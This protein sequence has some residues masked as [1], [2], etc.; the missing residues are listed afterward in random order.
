MGLGNKVRG[1]LDDKCKSKNFERRGKR[2]LKEVENLAT[3]C[4]ALTVEGPCGR[5]ARAEAGAEHTQG[6]LLSEDMRLSEEGECKWQP[7]QRT[8]VKGDDEGEREVDED[9]ERTM[10]QCWN[11]TG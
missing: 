4:E 9:D 6:T 10:F 8:R 7:G 11:Q 2:K 1:P 5:N 3:E